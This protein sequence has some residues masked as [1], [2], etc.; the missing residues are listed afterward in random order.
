MFCEPRIGLKPL[1]GLCRR[2]ATAV[3]AGIDARK[4]WSREAQRAAGCL[5][6]HLQSIAA[7]VEGGDSLTDALA[8][9]G[10]FFPPLFRELVAVGEQTGNLEVVL[11][12]L[13]EHYQ[14][15]LT[16]RRRFL[17]SIVWPMAEL[18]IA[19]VVVGFLIWIV[20]SIRDARGKPIDILG[21]G[22]TGGGGL[23][24]YLMFLAGCGAAVWLVIRAVAR[25]AIWVQPVQRFALK[26]PLLGKPLET[27]ALARL[28]WS[29]QMTMNTGMDIRRA[30][31]LSLRGAGNAA[32]TD[33]T[34]K[35]DAE[36]EAGNSIH[37]AFSRAGAFPVEFLDT[38]AVGEESGNVVES[39][40]NLARQY[41][42]QARLAIAA[43]GVIAGWAVWVAVAVMIIAVIFRI[44]SFYLAAIG[45]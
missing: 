39:M 7:A 26:L 3:G 10:E 1:A 27:L 42:E 4:V 30:L 24:V 15:R 16:M 36:I 12:Q 41:A 8:R 21:F 23:A 20:G 29:M 34:A 13:A 44:F 33:L 40:G 5:G 32:Y 14:A 9:C 19:L 11:E 35:I 25:G 28:A 37:E 43:L 45:G 17:A 6:R 18:G 38:L 2:L 22:L 31:R